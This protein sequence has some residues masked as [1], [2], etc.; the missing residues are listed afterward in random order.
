MSCNLFVSIQCRTE[1]E[2]AFAHRGEIMLLFFP[3][4]IYKGSKSSCLAIMKW[5]LILSTCKRNLAEGVTRRCQTIRWSQGI[6]VQNS[7][8]YQDRFNYSDLASAHTIVWMTGNVLFLHI[9]ERVLSSEKYLCRQRENVSFSSFFTILIWHNRIVV[10]RMN[11][12]IDL[13]F[14]F[15]ILC[16]Y[17]YIYT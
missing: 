10:R 13:Q 16:L 11:I 6:S 1:R 4:L 2:I 17:I 9:G 8:W 14:W 12:Y 7:G 15:N 3:R 5:Y